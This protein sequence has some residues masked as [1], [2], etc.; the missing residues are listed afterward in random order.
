MGPR[1]LGRCRTIRPDVTG[2][3]VGVGTVR[4]GAVVDASDTRGGP[5]TTQESF[6]K[7]VRARMARTGER[8]TTARRV[9]L[10]QAARREDIARAGGAP[11]AWV[12]PPE[13]AD[14]AVREATGHGWDEW[15]ERIEADPVAAR[16]HTAVAAWLVEQH[17]VPGWWAQ[18]VTLGWE[19]ITGRRLPGQ[20]ADGTF[21]ANRQRTTTVDATALRAL[22]LD[23]AGRAALF[24]A[25][26]TTLR[27]RPASKAL[28]VGFEDG[29]AL[30]DLAARNDG[31]TT[32]TI[33]HEKLPSAD[34]VTLWKD[35]WGE[36]LE[37]L[38]DLDDPARSADEGDHA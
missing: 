24:P 3:R 5:M 35:F 22:L 29:V 14:A 7:R 34:A 10:E 16:G 1:V 37:A 26:D 33:A 12:S 8:Y 25:H 21:T 20:M 6:K 28:R 38:D 17:G 13:H 31:R 11:R 23:D 19:R 27:S 4:A 18:S 2:P 36:W 9:L 32:V 15:V 30:V